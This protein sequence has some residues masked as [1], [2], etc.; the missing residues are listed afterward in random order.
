MV[1][2]IT[3]PNDMR[4]IMLGYL[5]LGD[6]K[7]VV[8]QDMEDFEKC[9]YAAEN[10]YSELLKYFHENK[11]PLDDNAYDSAAANG[12]LEC[13]RYLHEN[14]CPPSDE[15]THFAAENGHLDCI[16]YLHEKG[17]PLDQNKCTYVTRK[18]YK[19]FWHD[20]DC[21]Q[22]KGICSVASENGHVDCLEYLHNN[23]CVLSDRTINRTVTNGHLECLMYL[24][25]HDCWSMSYTD[26]LIGYGIDESVRHGRNN[27]L[28]YL[29]NN[30]CLLDDHSLKSIYDNS[31]S[32]DIQSVITCRLDCLKCLHENGCPSN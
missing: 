27:C 11:C 21:H 16:K 24:H 3:L 4:S 2:S 30:G 18:F 26:L 8:T 29:Y 15:M 6:V 23:G 7:Y 17:Y 1:D 31:S 13:L 9:K 32:D 10:G 14:N 25:E 12:H 22:C 20:L 5:N 28:I 19:Q